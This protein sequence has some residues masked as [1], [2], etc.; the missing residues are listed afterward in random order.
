MLAVSD[1]WFVCVCPPY[2]PHHE[3]P[4]AT[5]SLIMEW[6]ESQERRSSDRASEYMN[7]P[8]TFE[9]PITNEVVKCTLLD[10]NPRDLGEWMVANFI[11]R[12]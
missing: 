6:I 12:N 1:D 8:R 2:S 9:E 4:N 11:F 7:Q 10:G 5:N 3:A